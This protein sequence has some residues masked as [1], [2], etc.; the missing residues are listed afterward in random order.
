[1]LRR[2]ARSALLL[3]AACAG[4]ALAAIAPGAS[5]VQVDRPEVVGA[6]AAGLVAAGLLTGRPSVALP[7]AGTE[8]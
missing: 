3:P 6:A 7:A 4:V 1:M 5:G 2:R 8:S